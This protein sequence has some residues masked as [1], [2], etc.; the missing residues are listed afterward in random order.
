MKEMY[1]YPLWVRIWHWL[2]ALMCVA[3]IITGISLHF[4]DPDNP[5]IMDFD[6]SILLHNYAG[7]IMTVLYIL[8]IV[9]NLVST[10]GVHYMVKF[11]GFIKRLFIQIVFY[12]VGIFKGDE[13]P[14]PPTQ[15]SKFNPLQQ[16]TYTGVMYGLVAPLVIT[17]VLLIIPESIPDIFMG[18]GTILPIAIAHTILSYFLALFLLGHL[19]LA[20][21]GETLLSN[22]KTMLTGVHLEPE[23]DEIGGSVK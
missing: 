1:L 8:F 22:Y 13:H 3:L 9:G 7:L 21:T 5:L 14:Y 16:I 10:N 17:G 6:T 20:T 2:N 4:S 18:M 23:S 11:K 19:Y 12:G 15:T